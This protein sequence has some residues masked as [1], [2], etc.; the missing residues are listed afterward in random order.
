LKNAMPE[1]DDFDAGLRASFE[2][3]TT[4]L[5]E[6][7]MSEDRSIVDL[8]NPDFTFVDERLAKHYG[9]PNIRGSRFRRVAL[10]EGSR[11]GAC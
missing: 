1:S 2:R 6:T 8:L 3:E 7:V 4:M 5:F 9:F 10:A 11:A